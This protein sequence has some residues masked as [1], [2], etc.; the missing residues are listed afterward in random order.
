MSKVKQF[1]EGAYNLI[2]YYYMP[3]VKDE[4]YERRM[5]V[6]FKCRERR[7]SFF[8]NLFGLSKHGDICGQCGCLIHKKCRL[9][10]EEC[11][12]KKWR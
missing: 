6:C 11:P 3:K 9:L 1:F 7:T 5:A 12:L 4:R 8:L 2:L 10:F